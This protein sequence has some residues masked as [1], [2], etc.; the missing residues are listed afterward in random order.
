MLCCT[1]RD[2]VVCHEA[3][4]RGVSFR[5]V[6]VAGDLQPDLVAAAGLAREVPPEHATRVDKLELLRLAPHRGLPAEVVARL[7]APRR[8]DLS[9]SVRPQQPVLG[10]HAGAVSQVRQQQLRVR[11]RV[12]SDDEAFLRGPRLC[13]RQVQ[14]LGQSG[15]VLANIRHQ[16][17][18]RG[19]RLTQCAQAEVR[20]PLGHLLELLRILVP[21]QIRQVAQL[22]G[23]KLALRHVRQGLRQRSA[24]FD[25]RPVLVEVMRSRDLGNDTVA[26]PQVRAMPEPMVPTRR[27]E[28]RPD[29]AQVLPCRLLD[30][31]TEAREVVRPEEPPLVGHQILHA[32]V[33]PGGDTKQRRVFPEQPRR[34]AE[35]PQKVGGGR[36]VV[37]QEE[38]KLVVPAVE[39]LSQGEAEVL[40]DLRD[41]GRQ[42]GRARLTPDLEAWQAHLERFRGLFH[43][44]KGG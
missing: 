30:H 19:R 12:P 6:H 17:R 20:R 38:R 42:A 31:P 4:P 22:T 24:G 1:C 28:A 41:R 44:L 8:A 15:I 5:V 14:R 40:G 35:V 13:R 37:L 21:Q 10:Q 9:C 29:A 32:V 23:R 25:V 18:L 36:Q 7:A 16:V 3:L 26:I 33:V 27:R 43:R 11:R 2:C 34:R 39:A